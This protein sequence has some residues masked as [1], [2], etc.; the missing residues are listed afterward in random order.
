METDPNLL[1]GRETSDDA[2]VYKIR[3][4]LALIQTLDFF[5]PIV[6]DPYRFGQIAAVNALSDVYAMG[7]RPLTAMNI[8]GFPKKTMDKAILKEIL[9]G[10]LEKIHEAGALLVGGH[11]IDDPELKYGLSVTGI[12]HPDRVV[13]NA[14]ARPGDQLL[15]TKPLG[16][17]IISTALKGKFSSP[18]AEGVMIAVMVELNRVGAEVME[19][20]GAQACTD[21]TGF[22]LLGHALEMAN[23]SHCGIVLR[24]SRVPILSFAREYAQMGLVP[25]GTYANRNFCQHSL[26]VDPAIPFHV[27]DILADAQTSGGLLISVTESRAAEMLEKLQARGIREAAVIGEVTA[28]PPGTITVWP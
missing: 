23:S 3:D 6:N 28:G 11:S 24:A 21:I 14:G 27:L 26:T 12:V 25:A 5:T 7:G 4:D 22:G 10:G 19:E 9:R 17:G 1:V 8:V 18:E 13:T 2:G 15:L 16:T 20:V